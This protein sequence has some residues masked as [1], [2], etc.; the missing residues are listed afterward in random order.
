[1][2]AKAEYTRPSMKKYPPIKMATGATYYY[3]YYTYYYYWS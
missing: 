2:V 1:M 3:Y